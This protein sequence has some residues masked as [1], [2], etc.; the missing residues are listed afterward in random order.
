MQ[1]ER[2]VFR[3]GSIDAEVAGVGRAS[4]LAAFA[5]NEEFAEIPFA[6]FDVGDL[7][8]PQI[9]LPAFP[10]FKDPSAAEGGR[11]TTAIRPIRSGWSGDCIGSGGAF[12][13]QSG[14]SFGENKRFSQELRSRNEKTP[15]F[16]SFA[17]GAKFGDAL[18]DRFCLATRS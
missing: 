11:A 9:P 2:F 15:R 14:I 16:V 8:F 10:S 1:L 13:F 18:F 3:A 12:N 6:L 7:N 4:P 17:F 5:I